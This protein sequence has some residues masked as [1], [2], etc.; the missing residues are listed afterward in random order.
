YGMLLPCGDHFRG[1]EYVCCP[2]RSSSSGKGETEEKDVPQ[3]L[4]SQSAGKLNSV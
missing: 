2:G 3:T 1:V 4:A